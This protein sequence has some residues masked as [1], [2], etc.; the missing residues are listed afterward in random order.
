MWISTVEGLVVRLMSVGPGCRVSHRSVWLVRLLVRGLLKGLCGDV[1][2]LS[3][4]TRLDIPSLS[5]DSLIC[6]PH[7]PWPKGHDPGPDTSVGRAVARSPRGARVCGG[8]GLVELGHKV[9]HKGV[10]LVKDSLEG[11]CKGVRGLSSRTR[12]DIPSPS[13]DSLICTPHIPWPEGLVPGPGASTASSRWVVPP[14]PPVAPDR[15]D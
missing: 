11:L 14:A 4:L 5:L 12:P 2:G 8:L 9:S 15:P 7:P 6:T 13:L 10:W 1:G 3:S